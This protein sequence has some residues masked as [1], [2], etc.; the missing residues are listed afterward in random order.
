[1]TPPRLITVTLVVLLTLALGKAQSRL[2]QH[3]N[4][5]DV[6]VS[7]ITCAPGPEIYEVYGHTAL[8]IVTP[9]FDAILNYGTFDFNE[10]NFLYRFIAGDADYVL[11]ACPTKFFLPYYSN[12]GSMVWE[13]RLNLT[14]EQTDTLM[15][16]VQR[17]LLPANTH[18]HYSFILDNCATRPRDVIEAAVSTLTWGSD[19]TAIHTFREIMHSYAANYAW[20][21]FGIDLA[22]GWDVD[23][24]IDNRQQMFAPDYLKRYAQSA[25]YTDSLGNETPLIAGSPEVIINVGTVEGTV[26]PPTP[27]YAIPL[28]CALALLLL[29]VLVSYRDWRRR[30]L[31]RWL[32]TILFTLYGLGGCIIIFL[33]LVSSHPATTRNLVAVWLNPLYFYP[34]VAIWLPKGKRLL[35]GWAAFHG[36]V[37]ALLLLLSPVLPQYVNAAFV[38]LMLIPII[39]YLVIFNHYKKLP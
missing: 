5:D 37:I 23:K 29:V 8:R 3:F 27:W 31:S 20:V 15:A 16:V 24:P 32:D 6:T 1:M 26:E 39:R 10:P 11:E 21:R 12:R 9:D 30:R 22:L 36:C 7:L 14:A 18:Y 25:H 34:L 33:V 17:N 38:P 13:Q 28:T 19:T 35:R 2:Q 4:P